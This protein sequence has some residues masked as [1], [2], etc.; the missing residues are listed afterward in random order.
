LA[1]SP[2]I[3]PLRISAG[4]LGGMSGP[5]PPCARLGNAAARGS[6]VGATGGTSGDPPICGGPNRLANALGSP[7]GL[8]G[9]VG[10]S[11]ELSWGL[12]WKL[13]CPAWS[14]A[15]KGSV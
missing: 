2:I 8:S 6:A 12:G 10:I 4:R 15:I 1:I 14:I 5:I 9:L 13:N 3:W 11:Q 7:I